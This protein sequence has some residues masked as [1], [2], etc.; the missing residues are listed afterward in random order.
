MFFRR[1]KDNLTDF[2]PSR[3]KSRRQKTV[4]SLVVLFFL[5]IVLSAAA[6]FFSGFNRTVKNFLP[7]GRL[8][9]TELFLFS[10]L[11]EILGAE[12]EKNYLFVFQNNMEMR[13]TGGFIGSYG[14]VTIK[15][16]KVDEIFIDDVYNLDKLAEGKLV[17][18]APWP[19][20]EYNK[21][22]NWYLR[23]ANWS[24]DW[25]T[26]AKQI[27]WFFSEE[28]K[29]AGLPAT[30]IDGI[31]AITPDFVADLLEIIGPINLEGIEFSHDNFAMAL[32]RFV[33][34]EYYE[35]GLPKSERKDIIGDLTG[36]IKNRISNFSTRELFDL[37]VTTKS[38]LDR[39]QILIYFFNEDLQKIISDNNWSG[40]VKSGEGDYLLVIDSNLA[41]L[42]TDSV[43]KKSIKY[44]LNNSNVNGDLIAKVAIT[45]RHQG[46]EIKDLISR[47]R[48]YVRVYA[49]AGAY[50][51]KAYFQEGDKI[52]DLKI[53]S[54]VAIGD[55]LGK[56]YAGVFLTV[57]PQK[58]KT[59]VFEYRL[60]ENIKENYKKGLYKFCVQKQA[61]TVGHDLKIN[62]NFNQRIST[63]ESDVKPSYFKG[64][65]ISW[66]TDLMVDREFQIKF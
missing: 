3:K 46:K 29:A 62:L 52:S 36:E 12:G 24:P 43:M 64:S 39:K 2:F 51:L 17:V 60:P 30:K 53:P 16:G 33:E 21:Q 50:F 47:Y 44:E 1:Q 56:K 59:L 31:I 65:S 19:M 6:F 11:S 28:R 22:K 27:L 63:Y 66:Q 13:P 38:N 4:G 7:S 45:Y 37:W 14:L 10:K 25:P 5:V 54:E 34:F 20:Q 26:S 18:P 15:N 9:G 35:R 41:A 48:D 23:D 58:E 55:D 40:E 57:E 32:E 42:K 61:G 8:I 49:P